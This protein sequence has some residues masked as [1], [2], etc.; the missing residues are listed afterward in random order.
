VALVT[1]MSGGLDST[2]MAVLIAQEGLTQYPL[3]I[4]YGQRGRERELMACRANCQRHELP[5]PKV[6]LLAGYGELLPCGLTD[7]ARDIRRDAFLPG[8]NLLFVMVAAAYARQVGSHT[9]AIGLLDEAFSLFPDQTR[10]FLAEAQLLLS[11]AMDHS[12]TIVGPLMSY[13]KAEVVAIAKQIGVSETYSCHAGGALPC[14]VCIA[15]LEY[16]DLEV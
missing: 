16:S 13:S 5:E 12:V 15:C 4:D 11:R 1:L 2:V 9:V 14:G 8:R 10:T 6:A 7:P 3:F